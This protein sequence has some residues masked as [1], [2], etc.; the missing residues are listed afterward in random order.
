IRLSGPVKQTWINVTAE[1]QVPTQGGGEDDGVL[2]HVQATGRPD[3]LALD[4]S[5]DPTMG[6]EDI[7]SYIVTGRPASDNPLGAQSEG[8][9][10][11]Q[12]VAFGQ[13]SDALST[14]AGEGLGFD[15]FQIRQEGTRG[16]TLNA[17]R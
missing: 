4:F 15:V 9:G 10:F 1:Y 16:L 7:L 12:R 8:G 14:R 3:S 2:I 11:G 17:G 6:Q 13:L 5:A